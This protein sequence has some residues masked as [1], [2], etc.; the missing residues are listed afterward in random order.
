MS[1]NL[2]PNAHALTAFRVL[3]NGNGRQYSATTF[4]Q[5]PWQGCERFIRMCR[6]VGWIPRPGAPAEDGYAVLDVIDADGDIIQDFPI[7]DAKAFQQI[8]RRLHLVVEFTDGDE[9]PELAGA[10]PCDEA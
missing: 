3:A 2:H 7:R 1:R 9:R 10:V 5:N 4:P 6:A 8:K